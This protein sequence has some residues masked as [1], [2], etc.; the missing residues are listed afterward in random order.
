M[1]YKSHC[2]SLKYLKS[3][4]SSSPMQSTTTS[5]TTAA[6]SMAGYSIT[7]TSHSNAYASPITRNLGTGN[8]ATSAP[9]SR[10]FSRPFTTTSH[11]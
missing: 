9:T 5:Q 10:F 4:S 3:V 6:N 11:S 8:G 1:E 7:S 2:D